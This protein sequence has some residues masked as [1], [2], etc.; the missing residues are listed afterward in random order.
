MKAAMLSFEVHPG[1]MDEF[2][3]KMKAFWKKLE[4]LSGVG[5]VFLVSEP[6]TN[7]CS[8][9]GIWQTAEQAESFAQNSDFLQFKN[10]IKPLL[11]AEPVRRIFDVL[12]NFDSLSLDK[13]AIFQ[14]VHLLY[15]ALN[16]QDLS[17]FD[18]LASDQIEYTDFALGETVRGR[19][20]FKDHFKNWW[21]AFPKG[22]GEIRNMI[23]SNDQVVVEVL[24]R[25][26]QTGAFE[27]SR[28]RIEP[29]NRHF[30]FHFCQVFRIQDGQ[31]VRGQSYSDAFQLFTSVSESETRSAA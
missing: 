9:F 21:T 13:M 22:T 3:Q 24:G 1:K 14:P 2:S 6:G 19:S 31:I 10:E 28:G 15:A 20:A 4:N 25:G 23:V 5:P 11:S 29:T 7:I 18:R 27:T 17:A 26:I 8:N 16:R 30:E 12:A